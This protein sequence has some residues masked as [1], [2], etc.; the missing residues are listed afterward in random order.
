[1]K[2]TS[3]V[4][5]AA[6]ISAGTLQASEYV[7]DERVTSSGTAPTAPYY[8]HAHGR[9]DHYYDARGEYKESVRP[10]EP[11]QVYIGKF[12]ANGWGSVNGR[13]VFLPQEI[14]PVAA[15]DASFSAA[16]LNAR[17]VRLADGE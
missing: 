13:R 14:L 8:H 4:L 2:K 9:V 17:R 16:A 7:N 5:V 1:M 6:L 3:M 15:A 12:F 10:Y 11:E